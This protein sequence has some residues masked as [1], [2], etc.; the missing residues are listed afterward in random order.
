MKKASADKVDVQTHCRVYLRD[1]LRELEFDREELALH[2]NSCR[3]DRTQKGA[4]S[5]KGSEL[6]QD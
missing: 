5:K 3:A 2:P 1:Y 6:D 4:R